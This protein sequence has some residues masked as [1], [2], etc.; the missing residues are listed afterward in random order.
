[1]VVDVSP[2][3]E[4]LGTYTGLYYI[5]G[6]S[7]VR[8]GPILNGWITDASGRNYCTIFLVAPA[9]FALA[10]LCMLGVTKG[11]AKSATP[12]EGEV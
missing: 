9:F 2:S 1:M 11:E 5:A 10:I 7:A 12:D 4:V 8:V 3:E 6:T